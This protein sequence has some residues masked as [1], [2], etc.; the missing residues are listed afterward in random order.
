[1]TEAKYLKKLSEYNAF[2]YN[3]TTMTSVLNNIIEFTRECAQKILRLKIIG[4]KIDLIAF[5]HTD[6]PNKVATEWIFA[7]SN[8]TTSILKPK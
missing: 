6:V 2:L 1:M 7:I 3:T 8:Y 4:I 5:D